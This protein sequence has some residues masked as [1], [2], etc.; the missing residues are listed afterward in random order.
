MQPTPTPTPTDAVTKTGLLPLGD[1]Q[2][3]ALALLAAKFW[4]ANPWLTLRYT[5]PALFQVFAADYEKAVGSRQQAGSSRPILADEILELD[6][7]IDANLYRVK[8]RLTDK[9]DKKKALKHYPTVGIV[10]Y[11]K[12]YIIDRERSKRAAALL[13]LVAGLKTEG[14]EAGDWGKA[15]WTPIAKRYNELVPLLADSSGEI[16]QAVAIK[17]T[18][19]AF[20][21][22]VLYALAKILDANYPDRTEYKAQLRAAGFQRESY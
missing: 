17:D 12:E 19:R 9:Y 3:A 6:H 14:I 2:L 21:E 5:T 15:Y 1:R 8:N 11:L 7:D 22:Q 13:T 16:S 10:K 18:Q 20:V 4:A